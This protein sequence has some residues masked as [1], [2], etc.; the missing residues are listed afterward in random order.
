MKIHLHTLGKFVG[1]LGLG[2]AMF[3]ALLLFGGALNLLVQWF[4]PIVGDEDF[5]ALMKWVEKFILYGDV[6]FIGWWAI[7]STYKAI[8]EMMGNE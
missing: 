4:A 2:A 6:T 8:K 1:H 3:G 7:F 5:L